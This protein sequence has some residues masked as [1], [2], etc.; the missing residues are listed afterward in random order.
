M[1]FGEK[2]F[3]NG[4]GRRFCEVVKMKLGRGRATLELR[5]GGEG[6]KR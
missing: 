1:E 4:M 6:G 2:E 3:G 5:W